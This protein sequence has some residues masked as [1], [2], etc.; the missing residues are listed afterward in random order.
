[1]AMTDAE[2]AQLITA[3]EFPKDKDGR[4]V[5]P[6]ATTPLGK[7]LHDALIRD[8]K[9][10]SGLGPLAQRALVGKGFTLAEADRGKWGLPGNTLRA[11]GTR[12]AAMTDADL[13]RLITA[14]EFPEDKDGR[15]VLPP[16][17]TPLG[18]RLHSAVVRD[19]KVHSGLGPLA[20]QA[21]EAKG[22]TPVEADRGKWGLPGNT[23]RA[24]GTPRAPITDADLAELITATEFQKDKDGRTV[25]PPW[26]TPLG[27]RLDDARFRRD[28]T[29]QSRL[30]PLARRALEAKGF[31][32]VEVRPGRWGLSGDTPRAGAA[33]GA[34]R[35]A[36]AAS[37][38]YE[39]Y[40]A[41]GLLPESRPERLRVVVSAEA[42]NVTGEVVV[43]QL[44]VS[45]RASGS[46][47]PGV[48]PLLVDP[49]LD[50]DDANVRSR[51]MRAAE[52][53]Q[54]IFERAVER[55]G[56]MVQALT[57]NE[58]DDDTAPTHRE[59]YAHI[60]IADFDIDIDIADFEVDF[61]VGG[62]NAD[63]IASYPAGGH[64]GV[65][66]ASWNTLPT[67]WDSAQS[68]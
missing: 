55:H 23:L 13:A 64:A 41:Y 15:T 51:M 61:A 42:A 52:R 34:E 50:P 57:A 29:V 21:L 5:L 30:G 6:P 48:P 16:V 14:T 28:G 56:A 33:A 63:P 54:D 1:M 32:L 67:G 26:T 60:D 18:Q 37:A 11:G 22:F 46:L 68:A 47:G 4:T 10:R 24:G 44:G 43:V 58:F 65:A 3:T 9:M 35:P 31:T 66:A 20:R 27:K 62:M 53:N 36:R 17:S 12:R 7:R 59:M 39:D 45:K 19:G 2:L 38:V 40:V 49:S 8:G 25:L